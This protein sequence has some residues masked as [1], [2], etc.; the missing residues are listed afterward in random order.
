MSTLW[1]SDADCGTLIHLSDFSYCLRMQHFALKAFICRPIC[2]KK[3]NMLVGVA[4]QTDHWK[5][6]WRRSIWNGV[7]SG[8]SWNW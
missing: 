7:K 8:G 2:D 5:A 6:A 4:L 3:A 1:C